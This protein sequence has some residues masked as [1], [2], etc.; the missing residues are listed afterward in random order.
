MLRNL[1][2]PLDVGLS[3][4]KPGII[5]SKRSEILAQ[6]RSHGQY[7]KLE[8]AYIPVTLILPVAWFYECSTCSFYRPS[9]KSCEPVSGT[10]EPFAWCL[11]WLPQEND[12]PLSWLGRIYS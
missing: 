3:L 1:T 7:N 10:I 8:A 4:I 9:S 11:L 2:T 12:L 5:Q 6:V